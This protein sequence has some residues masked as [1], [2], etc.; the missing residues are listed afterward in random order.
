MDRETQYYERRLASIILAF[1]N[2]ELDLGSNVF[3]SD[4]ELLLFRFFSFS[5]IFCWMVNPL[6]LGQ[7]AS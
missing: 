1:L 7:T 4:G 5:M 3:L 2:L 6:F